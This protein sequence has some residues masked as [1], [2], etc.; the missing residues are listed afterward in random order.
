[1]K[2]WHAA[3]VP[4]LLAVAIS[5][6]WVP[7]RASAMVDDTL[8]AKTG[9]RFLTHAS[10]AVDYW[11]CF[12]PDGKSVLFSRQAFGARTWNLFIVSASGG[13]AHL[14][15]DRPMPV[16]ATRASWSAK[17][18]EIA[19]SGIS[20]DETSAVWLIRGDGTHPRP[21][22]VQGVSKDIVYPSWYPDGRAL[23]AMDG[24]NEVIR[25]IDLT[26]MTA[27]TV[28]QHDQVLAG[29]PSVSP[30]GK[31]IAFAGQK[32]I[33]KPYDQTRNSIWLVS[34]RGDASPLESVPLQGRAP[35]WSPDGKRLAFESN[36]DSPNSRF[37]AIFI[38]NR[39]GTGLRRITPYGINANHPVWSPDGKQLAFSARQ[40][41]GNGRFGPA[42]AITPVH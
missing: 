17:T 26:Q 41:K 25:R 32:N 4:A 22:V 28:T 27:T 6:Y 38:V 39:D 19:F 40:Q 23:A 31:W 8:M 29:M 35:S 37:Y 2:R 16:S 15:Q 10:D 42:I 30:D 18:S 11:P 34:D 5:T 36:R 33:G 3:I 21:L 7:H 24:D 9:V 12:S 14:F 13:D 20:P 1:M